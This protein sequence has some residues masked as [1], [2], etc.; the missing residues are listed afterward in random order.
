MHRSLLRV[1]LLAAL[2]AIAIGCSQQE[3]GSAPT[4][5][6]AIVAAT[7]DAVVAAELRA[8]RNNNV[9][10]LFE[11]SLPP[12]ELAKLKS[13][14]SQEMNRKPLTDDERKQFAEMMSK[15]TAPDAEAR[16]YAEIEPKLKEFDQKSAQ[17]LPMMIAFGQNLV[18]SAIQQSKN[19]TDAEKQQAQ[20]LLEA[21]ANWARN[22]KFT[23]PA[24]VKSAIA[25]IC[26]TA[27]DLNLKTEEELRAL[28]YDQFMQKAGIVLAGAKRVLAVYGIDL[29][30]TLDSAKIE[31]LANA[32]DNAKVKVTY[33][34]FDQPFSSETNLVR[35][36]GRWYSKQA[37]DQWQER[38]REQTAGA[39]TGSANDPAAASAK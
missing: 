16:L 6:T 25:A 5:A 1:T 34:A 8:L 30:R 31:L 32:G 26:K 28:T 14:W 29:D 33:T 13:E 2:T 36:D 21:V 11:I 35:L 18:Q 9:A 3:S 15:L 27:R 4:N 38:E 12:A 19:L 23:D 24:R 7:P 17:Q 10:G 22:T 37:L 20:M 39:A